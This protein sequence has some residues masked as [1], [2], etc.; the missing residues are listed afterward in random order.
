MLTGL[1]PLL[2]KVNIWLVYICLGGRLERRRVKNHV[3]HVEERIYNLS[4]SLSKMTL[5]KLEST[6]GAKRNSSQV[7]IC[8]ECDISR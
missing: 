2:I 8:A 1:D 3:F 7:E 4:I 5:A 6:F